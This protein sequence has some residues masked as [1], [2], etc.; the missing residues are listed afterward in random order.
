[1]NDYLEWLT[2]G[3]IFLWILGVHDA[4]AVPVEPGSV[5]CESPRQSAF[6]TPP[7]FP[8]L[9]ARVGFARGQPA[10]PPW[11]GEPDTGTAASETGKRSCITE[12]K[13]C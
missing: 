2:A 13:S 11:S 12:I 9:H 7:P 4:R 8:D 6:L 1:M 10:R 5:R 3:L